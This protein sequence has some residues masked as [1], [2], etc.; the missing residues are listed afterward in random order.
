MHS[1]DQNSR[2]VLVPFNSLESIPVATAA[3]ISGKSENTIRLWAER[4]VIGRK[5]GGD[6]HISRVALTIFLDGDTDALAAYHA[7]DRT[8]PSVWPYFERA[9]CKALLKSK[10]LKSANG[11]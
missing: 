7:G 6:W 4:Y 1:C 8:N 5:I 3:K 10:Q 11:F 9:G 2:L